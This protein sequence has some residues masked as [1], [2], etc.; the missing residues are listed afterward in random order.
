MTRWATVSPGGLREHSGFSLVEGS[1]QLHKA[2]FPPGWQVESCGV[3]LESLV[4]KAW[5]P[6]LWGW[7]PGNPI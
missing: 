4:W 7:E 1:G 6:G 3:A 2:R 5:D